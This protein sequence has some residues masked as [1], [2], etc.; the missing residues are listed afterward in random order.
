MNAKRKLVDAARA[1]KAPVRPFVRRRWNRP[2]FR[3]A[4]E[5]AQRYLRIWE[6]GS[7][8]LGTNGE[9]DALARLGA[10]G[11]GRGVLIDVGCHVGA[12]TDAALEVLRPS[13][14]HA[15]EADPRLAA[16]LEARY[17]ANPLVVVNAMGMAEETGTQALFVNESARDISSMVA[18]EGS[19]LE[20]VDVPVVRGDEYAAT[21]G[22]EAVDYL[23]I[24]TEGFDWHVLRGFSGLF[25]PSLA[26]VQF[27]YNEWNIR[28]RHLLADF[29]ELL[30]PH[31]YRIGKV[32]LNGVDF[33]SY[34]ESMENW[35]GPAC[36]A[37]H[38]SRPTWID[39]LRV[40]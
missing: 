38:E 7:H 28:S 17:S 4:A 19:G 16:A 36:I 8:D 12:W 15:F 34:S 3:T 33:R 31:G 24:D 37:V 18:V 23:K 6:N 35:V 11:G 22:I 40:R 5:L 29:Y 25:G 21:S 14:V 1:A 32:H 30:E 9:K 27:E 20:P 10:V 2:P 13:V 39:A 26:A